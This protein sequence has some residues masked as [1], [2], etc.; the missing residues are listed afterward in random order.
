MLTVIESPIPSSDSHVVD[1][2]ESQ[3]YCLAS[4]KTPSPRKDTYDWIV[5]PA[6]ELR[7][8]ERRRPVEQEFSKLKIPTTPIVDLDS[9]FYSSLAQVHESL[10]NY[11]FNDSDGEKDGINGIKNNKNYKISHVKNIK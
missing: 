9:R 5:T 3:E 7:A 8:Q 1:S 11:T 6:L 2:D 4:S 10:D